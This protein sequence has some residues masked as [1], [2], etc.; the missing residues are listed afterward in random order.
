[1]KNSRDL[2]A[3]LLCFKFASQ[4]TVGK[5]KDFLALI[6]FGL[7]FYFSAYLSVSDSIPTSIPVHHDDYSNYAAGG[8][9]WIWSWIRPLST[10][11]I[12]GL[13]QIGPDWLIWTIRLLTVMF[14][15]LVWKLLCEF[16]RPTYYYWWTLLLFAVG[17]FSTPIIVEYARYTGMITHLLSGCLGL[18]A[19]YFLFR[20]VAQP[21]QGR[22]YLSVVFLVLSVLAKEDFVLLYAVSLVYAATLLRTGRMRILGWGSAGLAVCMFLIAGAKFMASSSFLG[23]LD[24]TSPYYVD[25]SPGGILQ[26]MWRYLVGGGHP[27][28]AAHGLIVAGLFVFSTLAVVVLVVLRKGVPKAAYFLAATLSVMTPYSLLPNHVNAYYEFIWLPMLIGCCFIAMT[29]LMEQLA[30]SSPQLCAGRVLIS[31]LVIV[32]A[33]TM[34][35]YSRRKG[36]AAWYDNVATSNENIIKLLHSQKTN[37]NKVG[38][39]CI[40]GA[41][42]FSPWFMHGG[43]YLSNVMGLH[44]KWYLILDTDSP[45]YAG[46]LVGANGSNGNTILVSSDDQIPEKCLSINLEELK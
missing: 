46:M 15:F 30:E 12:H 4:G 19:V 29:E 40:V 3:N 42:S 41:N 39:V 28:M 25:A 8:R 45:L 37:I 21:K 27:A 13:A 33:F 14:V 2:K 38:N 23:V 18:C 5:S 32:G 10:L 17:S 16:H 44:A 11:I 36:I 7:T 24:T 34:I 1:M 22:M 6:I 26:T 20:E 9:P 43:E 35:D 31:F